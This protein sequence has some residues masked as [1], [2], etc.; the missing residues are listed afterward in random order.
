MRPPGAEGGQ[1]Q[2]DDQ[3]AKNSSRT[4]VQYEFTSQDHRQQSMSHDRERALVLRLVASWASAWR[5]A[6]SRG[7]ASSRMS[8]KNNH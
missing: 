3:T 7:R 1:G 8:H 5:W 2:I 6:L 4:R